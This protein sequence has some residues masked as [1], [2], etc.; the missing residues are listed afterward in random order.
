M[1]PPA[2]TNLQSQVADNVQIVK[3]KLGQVDVNDP[4][5]PVFSDQKY[6]PLEDYDYKDRALNADPS[7]AALLSAVTKRIEL[8]PYIGTELHGIQLSQ[9]TDKQKDELALL[10]AERGVVYFRDQDINPEQ[11]LELGR[12]FGRLHIHPT[13]GQPQ[14]EGLEEIHVVFSDGKTVR[15][16]GTRGHQTY[17]HSDVTYERQPPSYTSLIVDE[18]PSTGGDTLWISGYAAYDKLSPPYKKFLEGLHATHSAVEQAENSRKRGGPVRREPVISTHPVIRT[19]PVTGKKS[20][21]VNPIF[22][23]KIVELS[24]DESDSVLKYLYSHIAGGYDFMVRFKWEKNSVAFWDNRITAH[25]AIWNY[26]GE[27]RHG[28]RVTPQGERPF[29]HSEEQ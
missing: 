16:Y 24:E 19:H 21:F 27:R 6:P 3:D 7:K 1:S 10:I 29:Y 14:Q 12:Y 13:S 23:R 18:V 22:T 5:K 8:T 11:Q 26:D 4:N 15:E 17:W 25:T 2:A 28:H 9:L 20:L